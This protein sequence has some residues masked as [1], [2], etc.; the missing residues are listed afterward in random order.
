MPVM[1]NEPSPL[2]IFLAADDDGDTLTVERHPKWGLV[3]TVEGEDGHRSMVLAGADADRLALALSG[4]RR[5][6]PS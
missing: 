3:V 2:T 1:D 6:P 5:R 4:H